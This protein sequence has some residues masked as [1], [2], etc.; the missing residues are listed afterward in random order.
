MGGGAPGCE[1]GGSTQYQGEEPAPV[2][3][4][5]VRVMETVQLVLVV[6]VMFVGVVRRPGRG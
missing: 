2:V 1:Y 4:Q 6:L 3:V 5:L